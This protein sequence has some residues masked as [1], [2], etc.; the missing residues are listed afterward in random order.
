MTGN[1]VPF[2]RPELHTT[3]SAACCIDSHKVVSFPVGRAR[4]ESFSASS[5]N[6]DKGISKGKEREGASMRASDI[7]AT[8]PLNDY[9]RYW[10]ASYK[11]NSVKPATY[12]RLET[13]FNALEGFDI[14]EKPIGEIIADD[15]QDYVNQ[16]TAYGYAETTIKKQMRIVTAPLRHAA[17]QHRISADPTAGVVLPNATQV[18]KKPREV[19]AYNSG[20]QEMLRRILSMHQ[21]PGYAA[22]ELMLETGTR[23]GE[24]LALDWRN[25]DLKRRTV[26]I[27]ATVVRL[28]NKKQ[29]HVQS[30]A[31]SESSNRTIPLSKR[32][33]EVLTELKAD[34]E[35][36][37]V[38]CGG[39]GER[40]S[41][42]AL[43][44]QT[45]LATREAGVPYKGMHVFRHTFATNCYYRGCD[46]KILSKLLGHADV[47]I[48]YNTYI[49]LFGDALEE[50][51]AVV[52]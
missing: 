33:V 11:R 41:Y 7:N 15:I 39:D 50:M 16:L 27:E 36:L 23:V 46:V 8:T 6:L 49:H 40:L 4:A 18:K 45:Q 35:T 14:A 31:K 10:M 48:T 38:F 30:G 19:E 34:S 22:L 12:D 21:R 52:G 26:R 3:K 44:Y 42:E 37:S 1:I 17:A 5:A 2:R 43:R 28:A 51:R 13:S 47:N 9:I 25:V 32:A 24:A 20:E 29:S